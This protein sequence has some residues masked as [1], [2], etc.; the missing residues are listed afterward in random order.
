MACGTCGKGSKPKQLQLKK[1]IVEKKAK[2]L[3]EQ[4][5]EEIQ[6][7]PISAARKR[8]LSNPRIKIIKKLG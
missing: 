5:Q 1:L 3:K 7:T 8:L 6:M 2:T 4:P